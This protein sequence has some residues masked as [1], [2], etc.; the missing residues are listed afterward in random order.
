MMR[1]AYFYKMNVVIT[2]A[3][4]GIG[5]ETAKAL[6]NKGVSVIAISRNKT[7]LDRL[8]AACSS[9]IHCIQFDLSGNLSDLAELIRAK[10]PFINILVNNAGFLVNKPFEATDR[11]DILDTFEINFFAPYRLIQLLLPFMKENG[12]HI[13]NI[14]SMGGYQG[15]VKFPGLTAYSASKAALANLTETLA[16]ELKELNIRLN[17]LAPGAVDTDMLNK[18]FP[19]Y[20]APV[21]AEAIGKFIADFALTGDRLFNGKV[22][23]VS[24]STP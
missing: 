13:L 15:S 17:C 4:Q 6:S 16:A 22:I 19:S 2:G 8:K 9:E 24:L 21:T 11:Q 12:A 3:G 18:A 5:F 7:N 1:G 23:P 20:K 14:G 10:A